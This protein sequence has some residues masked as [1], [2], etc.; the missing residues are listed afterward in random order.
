MSSYSES[1]SGNGLASANSTASSTVPTASESSFSTSSS[2]VT[3]S[4]ESDE[5]HRLA[6]GALVAGA[7]AEHAQ[8]RV[9]RLLVVAGQGDAGRE[10]QVPAHDPVPAEEAAL[11][12][13]QVHRAAAPLRAPVHAAEELGHH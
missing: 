3:P 4:P 8:H 9:V 7:V 6:E 1:R 13:E 5:V 11:V 12:V 10:R 2:E